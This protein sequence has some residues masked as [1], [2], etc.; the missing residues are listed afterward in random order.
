MPSQTNL[1]LSRRSLLAAGVS[2]GAAAVAPGLILGRS[3]AALPTVQPLWSHKVHSAFGVNALPNHLRSG[4]Q[5]T[6]QWMAALDATN[7]SYFRGLYAHELSATRNVVSLARQHGLKWGM[8]AAE[9]L[10]YS[11]D[12]I[13]ARIK[14][15]ATN[16]ADVCLYIEG[17]NEPNYIRGTGGTPTDWKRRT[18]AKQSVIWRAVKSYASLSHVSVVGP[19]L[20]DVRATETDY[21]DLANMGLLQ[22]MD[23]SGIHRYPGGRYPDYQLD[24]TLAMLRRTWPGKAVWISETGYSNALATTGGHNPVPEDVSADYGPSTLLEAAARGCNVVWFE[25]LDDPDPGAKDITEAN[26]GMYATIGATMGPSWR[27]KPVVARMASFL[28]SLRDPGTTYTPPRIALQVSSASGDVRSTVTA[29]RNG[30]VTVHVRRATEC[31]DPLR[32][33]RISVAGVPVTI[34]TATSTRTVTVNHR[35]SSITL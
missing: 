9:S 22:Y 21:R 13:R 19:S 2:G 3:D 18:V 8:T 12:A 34:R 15:I 27:A 10:S 5:Y 35:V 4:Y 28:G 11:D 14:H 16:A 32:R 23:R 24:E 25:L 26:L 17:V 29:K 7:A 33:Q 31:W 1:P 30:S 20:Q 6:R